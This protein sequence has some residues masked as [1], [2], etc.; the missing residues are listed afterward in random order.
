MWP[1]WKT[2]WELLRKLK[3][4]LPYDSAVPLLDIYPKKQTLIQKDT[5]ALKFTAILLIIATV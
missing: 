2:V 5:C 3:I 1:L 4:E